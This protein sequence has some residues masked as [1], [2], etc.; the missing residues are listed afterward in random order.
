MYQS[1][2]VPMDGSPLAEVVLPYVYALCDRFGPK[3]TFLHVCQSNES[4]FMCDAYVKH[5]ADTAEHKIKDGKGKIDA[6]TVSGTVHERILEQAD[7]AANDLILMAA[8]GYSGRGDWM[9]G[10]VVH[11]VISSA[12]APVLMV[13]EQLP[14]RTGGWPQNAIVPL[15]G[16]SLSES[17]LPHVV[18]MAKTGVAVTLL[19]V[20]EPPVLLADYPDSVM[21]E[22]WDEHIN[23][24][25]R[26]AENACSVYLDDVVTKRLQKEG[27]KADSTVV[28]A[29]R[30]ADGIIENIGRDPTALVVMS[31]HG[32]S[33]FSR[34]PY[35]H[36]TDRV[37]LAS[38]NP[39]LL[40][41]PRK[42]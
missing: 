37:V 24:A 18:A 19:R 4:A 35:G 38:K 26:S 10:S 40:V 11:K 25:K 29:D 6:T 27:V 5:L 13:R 1:I 15:D 32:R 39:V 33:G 2:L 9:L 31:T 42:R 36:V 12:K 22:G 34:W 8:H 14:N 7:K 17:V 3:V 30:A 28:L 16:S 20:C 41:R 21:P 23:L